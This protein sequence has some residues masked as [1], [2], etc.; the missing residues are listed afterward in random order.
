[1]PRSAR[2]APPQLSPVT[3]LL[4]MRVW[5]AILRSLVCFVGRLTAICQLLLLNRHF[6]SFSLKI[7]IKMLISIA[8]GVRTA[9]LRFILKPGCTPLS[10]TLR[11]PQA[12]AFGLRCLAGLAGGQANTQAAPLSE[13]K[14]CRR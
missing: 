5:R 13:L 7:S 10:C 4:G 2:P 9:R 6:S 1:M 14:I 11:Y 12:R 3:G 8:V